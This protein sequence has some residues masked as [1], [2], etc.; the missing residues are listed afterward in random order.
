MGHSCGWSHYATLTPPRRSSLVPFTVASYADCAVLDVASEL[1]TVIITAA[2]NAGDLVG[3]L[4]LLFQMSLD[5][6]TYQGEFIEIG[7]SFFAIRGN[8]MLQTSTTA[9]RL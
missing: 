8:A 9:E 2:S 6:L 7:A 5:L 3:D 4:I 1:W